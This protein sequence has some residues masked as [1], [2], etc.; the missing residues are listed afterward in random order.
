M[1]VFTGTLYFQIAGETCIFDM[2]NL[3]SFLIPNL[4]PTLSVRLSWSSKAGWF[5]PMGALSNILP[6]SQ[7][8]ETACSILCFNLHLSFSQG[9]WSHLKFTPS[10]STQE[11]KVFEG[12]VHVLFIHVSPSCST[13][14]G[15]QEM[16][17]NIWWLDKQTE[18]WQQGQGLHFHDS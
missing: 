13:Q 9:P 5:P 18:Q 15:T 7:Y 17:K 16:L 14:P 4:G 3:F 10:P 1:K 6:L 8:T 12:R 11:P 2:S